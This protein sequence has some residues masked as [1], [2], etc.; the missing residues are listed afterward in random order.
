M[1]FVFIDGGHSVATIDND[2]RH[3]LP[4]MHDG[5]IVL[6]DDYWDTTDSGAKAVVDAINKEKYDVEVLSIAD[7]LGDGARGRI[8]FAKVRLR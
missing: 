6:F 4:L 7:R 3:V 8:R 5:T 1:D 2:W